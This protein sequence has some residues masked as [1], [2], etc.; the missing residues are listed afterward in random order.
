MK[1]FNFDNMKNYETP[2]EWAERAIAT[3]SAMKPKYP[4][5]IRFAAACCCL[6]FVCFLSVIMF[7]YSKNTPPVLKSEPK[8]E[9]TIEVQTEEQNDF[10]QEHIDTMPLDNTAEQPSKESNQENQDNNNKPEQ[11]PSVAPVVPPATEPSKPDE[12]IPQS[13]TNPPEPTKPITPQ[14][15]TQAPDVP[16]PTEEPSQEDVTDDVRQSGDCIVSFAPSYLVGNGTIYC[17]I[18][19]LDNVSVGDNNL[20]SD[21]HVATFF[22]GF[23]SKYYY[24]YSPQSAGLEL[25]PGTYRYYFYNEHSVPICSVIVEVK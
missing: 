24:L 19:T 16:D 21:E 5:Y 15:P 23:G 22:S 12:T 6:V 13:P 18:K 1:D 17:R 4:Q 20:M 9:S 7:N 11:N 2:D 10:T 25:E 8:P 14:Q 3:A